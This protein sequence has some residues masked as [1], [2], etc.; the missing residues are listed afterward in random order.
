MVIHFKKPVY[1]AEDDVLLDV[2][3]YG[4]WGIFFFDL[5]KTAEFLNLVTFDYVKDMAQLMV[6]IE[7][8]G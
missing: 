7:M 6:M 5:E 4:C 8:S 1:G 3:G 2:H